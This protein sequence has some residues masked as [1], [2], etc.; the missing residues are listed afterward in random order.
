[1][2]YSVSPKGVLS[3]AVGFRNSKSAPMV[4]IYKSN[5]KEPYTL[6][7]HHLTLGSHLVSVHLV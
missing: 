5:K 1:M 6:I 4:R 2:A 7:H 3:I